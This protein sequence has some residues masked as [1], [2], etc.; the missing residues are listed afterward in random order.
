MVKLLKHELYALF[1]ILAY[2]AVAVVV[3]A[4]VGRLLA[5]T[6]TVLSRLFIM[7]YV[8]AILALIITA[9]ALG[10]SRFYKTMFSGEGYMT[11]SLPVS[12]T[13]LI[14][15]KLI[16]SLIA[17][18][19][20]T[21]VSALSLGIFLIGQDPSILNFLGQS[22]GELFM[23]FWELAKA[24]PLHFVDEIINFIV[25]LPLML[26]VFYSA[27]CLGQLSTSHR[28]L[29]TFGIVVGGYIVYTLLSVFCLSPILDAAAQVSIYLYDWVGIVLKAGVDVGCFF[30]VRY[31]LMHRVN[32]IV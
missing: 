25:T 2:I 28:R 18:A 11:L 21:V 12:A 20:A 23:G 31:I 29:L 3:F 24:D 30:L 17:M 1:R 14:F 4:A 19:F 27:L 16:S 15:A 5:E 32:L 10:I 7:F 26:L 9:W 8:F 6:E 13:E 22:I